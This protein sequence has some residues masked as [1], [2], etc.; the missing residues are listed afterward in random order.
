MLK[1]IVQVFARRILHRRVVQS[2]LFLLSKT[3]TRTRE[4]GLYSWG[5]VLPCD[6]RDGLPLVC[7]DSSYFEPIRNIRCD[8][9]RGFMRPG[10]RY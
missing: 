5:R 2:V 3:A 4:S 7:S 9:A 6:G 1:F 10:M 8:G